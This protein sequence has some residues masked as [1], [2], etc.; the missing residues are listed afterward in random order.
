MQDLAERIGISDAVHWLGL[1]DDMP[2][3]LDAADAFVLS[4]AWEGMPLVVGEAM[5]MEKPVVATD[6]GGVREL[7]GDAG[8]VVPPKDSA[9]LEDA[10]LRVMRMPEDQRNALGKAARE[11][12]RQRFDINAKAQE[13]DAFYSHVLGDRR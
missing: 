5:A 10:M 4:S 13:W 3:L 9:A 11:R 7:I 12:I 1:R 2:S 8:V 6:V